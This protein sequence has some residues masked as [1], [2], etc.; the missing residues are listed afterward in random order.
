MR[1]ADVIDQDH[2]RDASQPPPL[3]QLNGRLSRKSQEDR[4]RHGNEHAPAPVEQR[5]RDDAPTVAAAWMTWARCE[6]VDAV[7][8]DTEN[9]L[10]ISAVPNRHLN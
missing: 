9:H 4:Q 10:S 8:F 7:A 6:G 5:D 1:P 3:D 2:G